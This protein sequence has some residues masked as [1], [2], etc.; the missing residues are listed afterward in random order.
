MKL[1]SLPA[2]H[3]GRLYPQ[4]ILATLGIEPA[5]FRVLAPTRAPLAINA[6]Y[7]CVADISQA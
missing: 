6:V 4:E 7:I 5:T 3:T 1:V 2:L